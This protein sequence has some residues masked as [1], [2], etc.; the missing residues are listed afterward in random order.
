ML[1]IHFSHK[2]KLNAQLNGPIENDFKLQIRKLIKKIFNCN[3]MASTIDPLKK[4]SYFFFQFFCLIRF[5]FSKNM[6]L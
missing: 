2:E 4:E 1:L 5:Y 6:Y 3:I